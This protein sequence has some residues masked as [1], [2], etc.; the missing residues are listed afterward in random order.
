MVIEKIKI[1]GA[2]LELP[3]KQHCQF[4]PFGPPC[5]VN[6]L[7]WQCC[8]AG[9]SQ[10]APRIFIFSI[11]LGAEFLSHLKSIETHARAFSRLISDDK[12]GVSGDCRLAAALA[13][14]QSALLFDKPKKE[15]RNVKKYSWITKYFGGSDATNELIN[16][17]FLYIPKHGKIICEIS[18]FKYSNTLTHVI[19]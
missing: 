19:Y 1:L 14:E 10:R 18:M 7:D 13:L 11:V 16:F 17:L 12:S 4:S 6:G 3:A 5:E 15:K 8:L 2:V 9:S